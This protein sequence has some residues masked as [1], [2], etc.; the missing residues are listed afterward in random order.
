MSADLTVVASLVQRCCTLAERA[1][2]T[3]QTFQAVIDSGVDLPN[4]P[5]WAMQ[6]SETGQTLTACLQWLQELVRQL[7]GDSP[8][9]MPHLPACPPAGSGP[10][11]P[12]AAD[13]KA[14]IDDLAEFDQG[15]GHARRHGCL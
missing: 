8:R 2:V 3:S 1:R 5:Q 13:L 12:L 14:L 6:L 9:G 7:G 11:Y 10:V 4:G 15:F